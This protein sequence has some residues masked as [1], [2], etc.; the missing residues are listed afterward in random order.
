MM[1]RKGANFL[2]YSMMR[3]WLSN[4]TVWPSPAPSC[5]AIDN[6]MNESQGDKGEEGKKG[7]NSGILYSDLNLG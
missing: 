6:E 2:S 5:Q 7:G 3:A 4:A 1:F